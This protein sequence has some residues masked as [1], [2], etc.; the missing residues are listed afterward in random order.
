M[1]NYDMKTYKHNSTTWNITL[2]LFNQTDT[3]I[4]PWGNTQGDFFRN[5]PESLINSNGLTDNQGQP[6]D[7]KVQQFFKGKVNEVIQS[8]LR[9]KRKHINSH[10]N[11]DWLP[12]HVK[13][14]LVMTVLNGI[15]DAIR[16]TWYEKTQGSGFTTNQ[17]TINENLSTMFNSQQQMDSAAW[18]TL[19]NSQID[20]CH[21]LVNGFVGR[22]QIQTQDKGIIILHEV[23][24]E[25]FGEDLGQFKSL[26]AA[27]LDLQ[28]SPITVEKYD[29]VMVEDPTQD[30]RK[31]YRFEGGDFNLE[32]SWED[33]TM[34]EVDGNTFFVY[35]NYILAGSEG[36]TGATGNGIKSTTY[37]PLT[38]KTTFTYDDG[39]TYTT[40]DLRGKDGSSY[41]DTEIQAKLAINTK[42]ISDLNDEMVQLEIEMS[43]ADT[44]FAKELGLV[45]GS[46]IDL[47]QWTANANSDV[48]ETGDITGKLVAGK[49]YVFNIQTG[50]DT[51]FVY[52][53]F[54]DSAMT[55][56]ATFIAGAGNTK[57]I[58][59][60]G[61][62]YTLTVDG[63]KLGLNRNNG[64]AF[65]IGGNRFSP[66]ILEVPPKTLKQQA[67]ENKNDIN[68]IKSAGIHIPHYTDTAD[69]DSKIPNPVEGQVAYV[70]TNGN[71]V[72]NTYENGN[73]VVVSQSSHTTSGGITEQQVDTKLQQEQ[74]KND[75]KYLAKAGYVEKTITR[76]VAVKDTS[77]TLSSLLP[78]IRKCFDNGYPP[79]IS[80]RNTTN[81]N[82]LIQISGIE[83]TNNTDIDI[84]IYWG[85]D[86]GHQQ[87]L[88]SGTFS[89]A[90]YIIY[91]EEQTIT[92]LVKASGTNRGH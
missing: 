13:E 30:I 48:W 85:D 63:D 7:A 55:Q 28:N 21:W 60:A 16:N 67:A 58:Y 65:W 24:N 46:P 90:Y 35:E 73:W 50:G 27:I 64:S 19:I 77:S 75:A 18:N 8:I 12:T 37:D 84:A 87:K 32:S 82:D 61:V 23:D 78:K 4:E 54:N 43:A 53:F 76:W 49:E 80:P 40:E 47:G 15:L 52:K 42:G 22:F 17:L 25:T 88:E 81:Y 83:R 1:Y 11:F 62:R 31:C 39:T 89:P 2:N 33:K 91:F 20:K 86:S 10:V 74:A 9:N 72:L 79:L 66:N 36:K 5:L 34:V 41:D 69:R 29:F 68:V 71:W 44:I 70:G 59:K 51:P 38:G 45:V 3:S 26:A 56:P 6:I 57:D 92:T 14:Q